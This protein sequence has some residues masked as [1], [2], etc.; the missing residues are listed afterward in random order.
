L[1]FG[2]TLG[3]ESKSLG[4]HSCPQR[5][6]R[7]PMTVIG[8]F[9]MTSML[10]ERLLFVNHILACIILTSMLLYKYIVT[11]KKCLQTRPKEDF[12]SATKALLAGMFYGMRPRCWSHQGRATKRPREGH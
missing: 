12:C 3:S 11:H 2:H 4:T 9:A 5:S 8:T 1:H 7:Y 10:Y 6:Q